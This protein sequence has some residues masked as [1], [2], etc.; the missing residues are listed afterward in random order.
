MI[1]QKIDCR[2]FDGEPNYWAL[3]DLR[4]ER[5]NLLSGKN[6]AGKT[7][8]ITKITWLGNMLAGIQPH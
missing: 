2:E 6:A 7:N 5:I 8:T 3:K 1:L 4:L